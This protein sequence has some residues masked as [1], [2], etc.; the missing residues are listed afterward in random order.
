M[1]V[2]IRDGRVDSAANLTSLRQ[3]RLFVTDQPA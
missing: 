2:R 3:L 1:V